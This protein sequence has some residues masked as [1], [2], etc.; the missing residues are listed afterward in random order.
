MIALKLNN[1][2]SGEILHY[3]KGMTPN[4]LL[5]HFSSLELFPFSI[6]LKESTYTQVES[7]W[8]KSKKL[9]T[10]ANFETIS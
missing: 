9:F 2:C 8:E 6:N 3:F 1:C 10:V 5:K 4:C 7:Y